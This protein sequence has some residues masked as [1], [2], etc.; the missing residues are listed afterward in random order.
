M[1][2][3]RGNIAVDDVR[4]GRQAELRDRVLFVDEKGLSELLV[5]RD[6]R[7]DSC[8]ISLTRPGD[9]AGIICVKD[10][11]QPGCK[12]RS[13]RPGAKYGAPGD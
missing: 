2:F 13:D 10:V 6:D 4:F 1:L 3:E 5:S 11:V 12:V 8:T 7:I 9:S